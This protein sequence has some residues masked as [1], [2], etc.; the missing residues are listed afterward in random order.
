MAGLTPEQVLMEHDKFTEDLKH[1]Y[2][3]LGEQ[4]ARLM[5]LQRQAA[6]IKS[7][8]LNLTQLLTKVQQQQLD[9]ATQNA[10]F[11]ERLLDNTE[12]MN[13]YNMGKRQLPRAIRDDTRQA[14]HTAF[15]TA[16]EDDSDE[17]PSREALQDQAAEIGNSLG[18]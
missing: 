15:H 14:F 6:A 7:Q 16:A 2:H 9:L 5:C 8:M 17:A 13:C 11:Y 10:V 1:M 3:C 4:E 12:L 18:Q